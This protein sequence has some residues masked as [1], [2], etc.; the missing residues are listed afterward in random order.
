[1]DDRVAGVAGRVKDLHFGP[2]GCDALG[3]LAAAHLRHHDVAQHQVDGACVFLADLDHLQTVARREHI[4]AVRLENMQGEVPE[5]LLVLRQ[6]D[7]FRAPRTVDPL[8]LS[9]SFYDSFA[10]GQ[11][12]LERRAAPRLA[13][14]PDV[15]AA[16]LDDP[17]DRGEPEPGALA[18]GLRREERLEEVLSRLVV[19]PD[20]V[21]CDPTQND[22]PS[23]RR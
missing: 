13:V 22:S 6:Q 12:D 19:D 15:S 16:L 2:Q 14:D 10:L 9:R 1:M 18:D 7:G 8:P 21:A 11:I 23:R 17:V 4:V 5:L 3:Q 20:A